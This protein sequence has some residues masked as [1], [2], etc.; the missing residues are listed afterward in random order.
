MENKQYKRPIGLDALLDD[1]DKSSKDIIMYDKQMHQITPKITL[2][3]IRS[4]SIHICVT[5]VTKS[6]I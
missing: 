1:T 6:H 5:R 3:T 2:N 4:K